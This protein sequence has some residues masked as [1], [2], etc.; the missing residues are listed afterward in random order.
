MIISSG[1]LREVLEMVR[2]QA[3]T[4]RA[5]G[6]PQGWRFFAYRPDRTALI[7]ITMS[8]IRDVEMKDGV[9]D[10]PAIGMRTDDWLKVLRT[11][12]GDITVTADGAVTVSDGTYTFKLPDIDVTEVAVRIPDTDV[13]A[14]SMISV[15]DIRGICAADPK[16]TDLLRV[17][18][19]EKGVTLSA[20]DD[21]SYGM[22]YTIPA[23]SCAILDGEGTA[24]YSLN[25]FTEFIKA[26]PADAVVE[27]SYAKD[28]PLRLSFGGR[29]YDGIWV[30]A[31]RIE[32]Q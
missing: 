14:T 6:S 28:L 25:I 4:V 21:N 13:T 17:I 9:P 29:G 7:D 19:N 5:Q 24:S 32:E 26:A 10:I 11:V 12:T 18:Q 16:R 30:L 20:H 2:T 22:T 1:T 8:D 3:D 27:M 31:P 15:K 23:A